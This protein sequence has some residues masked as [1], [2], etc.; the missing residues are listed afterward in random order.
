MRHTFF[1]DTT[2][3]TKYDIYGTLQKQ[4]VLWEF[5]EEIIANKKICI[6][7]IYCPAMT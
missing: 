7:V 4:Q 3:L 5:T 6:P 2:I 1:Q